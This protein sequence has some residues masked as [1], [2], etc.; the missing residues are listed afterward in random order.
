MSNNTHINSNMA[1][2]RWRLLVV[3]MLLLGVSSTRFAAAQTMQQPTVLVSGLSR[4]HA[5]AIDGGYVYWTDVGTGTVNRVNLN[6]QN[7]TT[8]ATGGMQPN[9]LVVDGGY[10]YWTDF[11]AG[12]VSKA[13]IAG[14]E[15]TVLAKQQSY[16]LSILIYEGYVYWA[17]SL[18]GNINRLPIDG[19]PIESLVT[20]RL[21]IADFGIYAGRLYWTEGFTQGGDV[22]QISSAPL[23]GG[24]VSF[25]VKALKPWSMV[26]VGDDLYWTEYRWG[27]VKEVSLTTGNV[28]QVYAHFAQDDDFSITADDQ[29]VYW[30]Q[31]VSGNIMEATLYGDSV[32]TIAA[33]QTG[34]YGIATDGTHLVWTEEKAGTVKLYNLAQANPNLIGPEIIAVLILI[35]A[36]AASVAFRLKRRSKLHPSDIHRN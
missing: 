29:H 26:I 2:L 30:T 21:G 33:N 1:P 34:P 4:P 5:V 16:P 20:S 6:G 14:G 8:I 17:E 10:V 25:F 31:R 23:Q 13:P 27:G 19:G 28:T 22:S 15:V 32:M 9:A 35:V 11:T 36:S 12:T 24:N 18:A 3:V 7:M